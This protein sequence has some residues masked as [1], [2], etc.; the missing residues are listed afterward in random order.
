MG[1]PN[2]DV[3]HAFVT[4]GAKLRV[5]GIHRC[6]VMFDRWLRHVWGARPVGPRS[7]GPVAVGLGRSI[8]GG[9]T[10]VAPDASGSDS[11]SDERLPMMLVGGAQVAV[12]PPCGRGLLRFPG[13]WSG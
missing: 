8:A 7:K 11:I 4:A 2:L 1:T 10:W 13:A 9:S 12:F 5:N 6:F 3:Q